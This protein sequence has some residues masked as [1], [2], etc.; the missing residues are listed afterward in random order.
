MM[1]QKNYVE[2]IRFNSLHFFHFLACLLAYGAIEIPK[3][4]FIFMVKMI[5]YIVSLSIPYFI[6]LSPS[7][8]PFYN[9]NAQDI[10]SRKPKRFNDKCCVWSHIKQPN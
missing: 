4:Y 2:G 5:T 9:S 1:S 7:F 10:P 8:E 3:F 6:E